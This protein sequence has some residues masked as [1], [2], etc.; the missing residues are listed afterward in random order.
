MRFLAIDLGDRRTGLA[1]GDSVTGTV[2]PLEV[3]EVPIDAASGAMLLEAI[4]RAVS[5]QI[6]ERSPGELV[7]GLPLNMDGTEGP[8]A[9]LVRAFAARIEKRTGRRV[10]FQDE[11]LTTAEADW[12]L[13]GSGLTRQRKK[14][15]RDALSAAAILR[16][17][18]ASRRRPAPGQPP[19]SQH[20]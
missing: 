13:A 12:A 15:R 10:H 6:G 14:E 4:A 1:S 16:D 2:S 17:F 18:L 5:E 19:A 8:R 7:V 3:L 9:R 20:E 11:R